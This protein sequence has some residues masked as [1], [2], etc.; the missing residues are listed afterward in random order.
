VNIPKNVTEI[1][2]GAGS[3]KNDIAPKGSIQINNVVL[4]PLQVMEYIAINLRY[5]HCQ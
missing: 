5:M 1:A 3:K 4:V 2:T